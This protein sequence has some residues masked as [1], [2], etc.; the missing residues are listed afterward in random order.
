MKTSGKLKPFAA[1]LLFAGL[2]HPALAQ[3]EG[4]KPPIVL[5]STGAFEVGG[6]GHQQAG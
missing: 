1:A 5:D 3:A 4:P 6:Q 2:G